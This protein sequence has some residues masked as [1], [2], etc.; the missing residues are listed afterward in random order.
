MGSGKTEKPEEVADNLVVR[1]RLRSWLGLKSALRRASRSS[2]MVLGSCERGMTSWV[3]MVGFGSRGARGW[4]RGTCPESSRE[5]PDAIAK[6]RRQDAPKAPHL[7]GDVKA[8]RLA[9]VKQMKKVR[10]CR[11]TGTS[12]ALFTVSQ[13]NRRSD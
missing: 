4:R 7:I 1:D 2:V 10:I 13:D 12:G 6:I 9:V 5:C 11:Q 8:G 3:S